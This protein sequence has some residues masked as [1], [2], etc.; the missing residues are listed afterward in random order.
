MWRKARELD[1]RA[2]VG[3]RRSAHKRRRKSQVAQPLRARR[4]IVREHDERERIRA[5]GMRHQALCRAGRRPRPQTVVVDCNRVR[6]LDNK[7]GWL[8][9]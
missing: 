3:K 9:A 1:D 2:V 6:V 4:F 5:L 7:A 8:S